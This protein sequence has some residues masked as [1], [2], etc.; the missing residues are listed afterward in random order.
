MSLLILMCIQRG[1]SNKVMHVLINQY[2]HDPIFLK[3]RLNKRLY[4]FL[5]ACGE[6]AQDGTKTYHQSTLPKRHR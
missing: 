5:G 4:F 3:L 6:P 1:L 2:N